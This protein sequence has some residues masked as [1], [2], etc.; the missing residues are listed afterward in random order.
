MGRTWAGASARVPSVGGDLA[1]AC[2]AALTWGAPPSGTSSNSPSSIASAAARN[3]AATAARWRS[4]SRKPH[5]GAPPH[6]RSCGR[7]ARRRR[8]SRTAF[9]RMTGSSVSPAP[10]GI[11][12]PVVS[13]CL[14]PAYQ[15][16]EEGPA[17]ALSRR[18]G[19]EQ[20][21]RGRCWLRRLIDSLSGGVGAAP[22]TEIDDVANPEH[23][24]DVHRLD[25]SGHLA[26]R[27]SYCA[28]VLARQKHWRTELERTS[29]G[30]G[31]SLRL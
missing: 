17:C 26:L 5:A 3:L 8:A 27:R 2:Q 10:S 20:L 4:I 11:R 24:D 12:S 18:A 22:P 9:R 7:C 16:L 15:P 21:H 25:G 13:A 28:D 31:T 14:S 29:S 6:W 30:E 23:L 1:G 19:L